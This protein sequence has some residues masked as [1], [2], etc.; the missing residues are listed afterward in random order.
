MQHTQIGPLLYR[1]TICHTCYATLEELRV[2][3]TTGHPCNSRI[4]YRNDGGKIFD[5]ISKLLSF[6]IA[7]AVLITY[8]YQCNY[9]AKI[10]VFKNEIDSHEQLC[11]V[12]DG[13]AQTYNPD[14]FVCDVCRLV[15]YSRQQIAE[16]MDMHSTKRQNFKCDQCGDRFKVIHL[17]WCVRIILY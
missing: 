1:C 3:M 9:C 10:L 11:R 17:K 4:Y 16:H 7:P 5:N 13:A 12:D 8:R 14:M 6:N 15:F 2:H